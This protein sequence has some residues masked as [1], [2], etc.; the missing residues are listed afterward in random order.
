MSV[1]WTQKIFLYQKVINTAKEVIIYNKNN[2]AEQCSLSHRMAINYSQV[3]DIL[4]KWF[5][6]TG[7]KPLRDSYFQYARITDMVCFPIHFLQVHLNLIPFQVNFVWF[8][9]NFVKTKSVSKTWYLF[10]LF[11]RSFSNGLLLLCWERQHAVKYSHGF[12]RWQY[13]H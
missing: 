10:V 11:T 5:T 1:M 9:L 12:K 7:A 13:L 6:S 2:D 4:C 3:C 8:S